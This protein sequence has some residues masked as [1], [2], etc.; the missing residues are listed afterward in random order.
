MIVVS[1]RFFIGFRLVF[2]FHNVFYFALVLWFSVCIWQ[3]SRSF[4]FSV[5]SFF[6]NRL[7][8]LGFSSSLFSTMFLFIFYAFLR[9]AFNMA[10]RW[11]NW[12]RTPSVWP[13]VNTLWLL[14]W[15]CK[16]GRN[17]GSYRTW[18]RV[19]PLYGIFKIGRLYLLGRESSRFCFTDKK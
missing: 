7:F 3:R 14:I 12:R 8:W 2:G 11:L 4:C 17:L 6:P 16:K 1:R 5:M 13:Y 10:F 18:R 19:L 9:S 15:F